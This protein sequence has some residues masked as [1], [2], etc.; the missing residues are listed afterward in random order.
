MMKVVL[1]RENATA[2]TRSSSGAPG[3]NV[4]ACLDTPMILPARGD[5][6]IKTG[7]AI[8]LPPFTFGY[9]ASI[10]G[11]AVR[12][13][14][15]L[16]SSIFESDYYTGYNSGEIHVLMANHSEQD[17][18]VADGDRIAQLIVVEYKS[19]EIQFVNALT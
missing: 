14:L 5:A 10:D 13:G 19:P 7:V 12:H 16:L 15:F 11:L 17:Y 4:Y 18:V 6:L 2:P 3:L 8:E 9:L 1:L